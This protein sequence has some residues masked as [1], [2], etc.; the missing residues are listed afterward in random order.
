LTFVCP[1]TDYG[2]GPSRRGL[3]STVKDLEAGS[4][5]KKTI[6]LPI[7]TYYTTTD[8]DRCILPK[9]DYSLPTG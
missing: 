4:I 8:T 6:L 9:A 7:G 5:I 3:P 2:L 1:R